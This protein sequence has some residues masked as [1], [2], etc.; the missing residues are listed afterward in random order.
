MA[1]VLQAYGKEQ[2]KVLQSQLDSLKDEDEDEGR[3]ASAEASARRRHSRRRCV[4]SGRRRRFSRGRAIREVGEAVEGP[5]F[6]R[7]KVE[8]RLV[9][10]VCECRARPRVDVQVGTVDV[11]P[12]LCPYVDRLPY[13]QNVLLATGLSGSGSLA[14]DP[15]FSKAVA[16]AL[17]QGQNSDPPKLLRP[18][19]VPKSLTQHWNPHPDLLS[20]TSPWSGKTD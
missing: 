13:A 2:C 10:D 6:V 11:T 7:P 4:W 17:N 12:S 8:P 9:V 20:P 5:G 14:L 19:K 1:G 16:T 3:A 18:F 15:W